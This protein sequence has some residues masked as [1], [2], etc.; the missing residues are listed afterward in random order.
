M[1]KYNINLE[2]THDDIKKIEDAVDGDFPTI[3]GGYYDDFFLADEISEAIYCLSDYA[4][5]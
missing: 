1:M 5:S 2:L 3:D 4:R